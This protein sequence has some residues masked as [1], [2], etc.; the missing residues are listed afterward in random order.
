[1]LSMKHVALPVVL[2]GLFSSPALAGGS[3]SHP[4]KDQELV[5]GSVLAPTGDYDAIHD[6]NGDTV[7]VCYAFIKPGEPSGVV[8]DFQRTGGAGG[9]GVSQGVT[10]PGGD[11]IGGKW[12][13][14]LY[15]NDVPVTSAMG[16]IIAPEE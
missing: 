11:Y 10:V 7:K 5:A 16:P 8:V 2:A 14:G 3:I 9:W 13:V 15:I 6:E 1:M 12:Y 4:D